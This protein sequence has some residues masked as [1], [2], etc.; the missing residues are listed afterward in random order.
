MTGF[1]TN[2]RH[3]WD[4]LRESLAADR[5]RSAVAIRQ[6]NP[7]FLPAALEILETPPNP[8]GRWILW[9]M[10]IFL[11]I[12]ILWACLGKV[13]TVA[14]A[15]GRVIPQGRVK[16]I[17]PADL[18]VVRAVHVREGQSVGAGAPLVELDPTVSKAEVEQARQALMTSEIDVA[19]ARAL[20]DYIN[21]RSGRF[22]APAGAPPALVATQNALVSAKISEHRTASAGLRQERSQRRS[23]LA[24]VG[25]EVNKLEEQLPLVQQQLTSM[26]ALGAQGYAPELRVAQVRE[27]FVGMRQDLA[28]RRAEEAKSR[29]AL[30]GA[31]EQLAKL[32]SQFAREALD[33][34]T[35]AEAARA[36]RAQELTKAADKAGLTIL[37]AP[38]AGVIQQVQVNTLGGV[39]KPADPLMVLVPKGGELI[40]E[41]M[42]KNRDA[43]FVRKGQAVEVK[44]EAFPFT[45]YGVIE[46]VV[47]NIS[48]DAVENEKTGLT[49]PVRVRLKHPWIMVGGQKSLLSPGMAA[50]AEIKTGDRR[51]IEYLLSPLLRRVK[52]AGRER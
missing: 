25:A 34:L 27:R 49:F 37:T 42:I 1:L 33:A 24:M 8:L 47:D 43:G 2:L 12:A 45:R 6:D 35:E 17:Q 16:I 32:D 39:V 21:G 15:E 3:H 50:T 40:V 4:V 22:N 44:L 13:D 51:I 38:E 41:A 14:M 9:A 26:Q 18:G 46:G 31:E 19:R 5:A 29:A 36:L 10:V 28:I 20:V 7:A 11:T 23:D 30:E 52:E 48:G